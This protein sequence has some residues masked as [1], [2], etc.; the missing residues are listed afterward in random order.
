MAERAVALL[1]DAKLRARLALTA[2]ETVVA[3]DERAYAEGTLRLL[4]AQ[5]PRLK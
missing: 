4:A 5:K 3:F 1:D 2:A